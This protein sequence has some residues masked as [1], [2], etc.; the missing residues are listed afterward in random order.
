MTRLPAVWMTLLAAWGAW[1]QD[2]SAPRFSERGY[3]ETKLT[4]F[5]EAAAGDSGHSVGEALVRYE[6]FYKLLPGLQLNGM[7]DGRADTHRQVERELRGD[8]EDRSV[9]RPAVSLRRFSASYHRGRITVEAGKQFI[10]WG[11]ADILN[12]TD[13][14][15]PRD[16]LSVI[17]NDFQGVLA[18]RVTYELGRDTF[19][20]VWAPRMTPSRLPLLGQRWSPLPEQ[21][22]DYRLVD[23][24]ARY[25]GRGQFGGRWNHLGNG[26]ECSFSFYDGFNYLPVFEIQAPAL[27]PVLKN[28]PLSLGLTRM[29]PPLRTYGADAAVPLEWFTLKGEAAWYQARSKMADEYVLYVIQL[30]RQIGE[31]SLVGGYAGE[32]IT[33]QRNSV[34]FSPDRGFAKT[35]L[36]RAGYTIDPKRSVALETAV[37]QNGEG[38]YVKAEYSQSIGQHWRATAGFV[39]LR[40]DP[41]DFLGQYRRNSNVLLSLRYSF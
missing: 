26:Y 39:L 21:A 37:R 40:G 29:Y 13:R 17:D 32:A 5:P 7:I 22:Q 16:F 35:F 36:A 1:A 6:A 12:P 9:R 4:L 14:F 15:A 11:K 20:A 30:E 34:S 41:R 18:G 31:L 19:D 38:T 3:V 28:D 23:L 27:K 33:N 10:R 25:P 8:W 24:G 2:S